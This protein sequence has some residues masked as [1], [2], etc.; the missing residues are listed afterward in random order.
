MS[1][2]KELGISEIGDNL[3]GLTSSTK[4]HYNNFNI[5]CGNPVADQM[6]SGTNELKNDFENAKNQDEE[7]Q[8]TLGYTRVTHNYLTQEIIVPTLEPYRTKEI[9]IGEE[10]NL[11]K[12]NKFLSYENKKS[13]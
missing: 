4:M 2:L 5:S 1:M 3:R 11:S 6:L 12:N 8:N 10:F 7:D 13:I 9:D